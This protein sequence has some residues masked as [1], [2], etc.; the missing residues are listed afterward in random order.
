MKVNKKIDKKGEKSMTHEGSPRECTKNVRNITSICNDVL[1]MT[2]F[3]M[4]I[5]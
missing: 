5:P 2:T 3:E 4:S 1:K